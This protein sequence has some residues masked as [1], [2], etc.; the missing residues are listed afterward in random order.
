MIP[1]KAAAIANDPV[2]EE[3]AQDHLLSGGTAPGSAL[4]GFFAAA[5]SYAGVLLGPVSVLVGGLGAG[6]RAFDGRLQQ[7]GQ[8][9][10][11][12]R[13]FRPGEQIP[14]AARVGVATSV[15]AA[16]VAFAYSGSQGLGSILKPGIS[17]AQRSGAELRADL[18]RR[19]REVGAAAVTE[20][21]FVRPMLHVAGPG[22]GGLVTA[23]DFGRVGD[24]DR[25]ALE[26]RIADRHLV[27][28]P[29]HDEAI[30][31]GAI[32]C[33]ICTVDAHGVF[34][35][36]SYQ[37]SSG[38]LGVDEL[39]LEVPLVAVPVRRGVTRTQPG[40]RLPAPAPI[41][42]RRDTGGQLCEVLA[43]PGAVRLDETLVLDPPLR[44]TVPNEGRQLEVVRK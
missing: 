30:A 7:P 34:C 10:R 28:P 21:Q 43:A 40:A 22:Q 39:E 5:G 9:M 25:P 27:L 29:W 3:A 23:A 17:R 18:L 8:G 14:D 42:L 24:V 6:A 37:R 2:A 35:A 38:G 15:T 4:C 36:L 19:I 31:T 11:R 1:V 20:A 44:L 13:G 33:A 32:G 26:R 16:L 41:A 12:P